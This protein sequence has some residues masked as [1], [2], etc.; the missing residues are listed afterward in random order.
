MPCVKGSA[1]H[2]P[3]TQPCKEFKCYSPQDSFYCNPETDLSGLEGVTGLQGV[4]G[5]T[6]ATGPQGPTGPMGL[7]GEQG[8]QGADG[9]QGIQGV[10][11]EQGAD[12]QQGEQGVTGATGPQGPAGETII[13]QPAPAESFD[14]VE[15][16]RLTTGSEN[17]IMFNVLFDDGNQSTG[18]QTV[19]GT[20]GTYIIN[21]TLDL[22]FFVNN[23]SPITFTA[24]YETFVNSNSVPINRI[25]IQTTLINTQIIR[26]LDRTNIVRLNAGDVITSSLE[27]TST[28]DAQAQADLITLQIKRIP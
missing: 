17:P 18:S 8:E 10:Q 25:S 6:G 27:L 11:G 21:S 1:K 12:G 22:T 28:G 7:Q 19:I 26:Y 5:V 23:D 16:E 14:L 2:I 20:T 24:D 4:Q 9:Q 13:F 3:V 15:L